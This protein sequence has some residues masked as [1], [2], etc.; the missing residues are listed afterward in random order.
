M[1]Y[2]M[3]I[4]DFIRDLRIKNGMTRSEL[5]EKIGIS[6]SHMNK[7][8]AG[9]RRPGM[10]TFE[11]ILEAFDADIFLKVQPETVHNKCLQKIQNVIEDVSEE[12]AVFLT[13]TLICMKHELEKL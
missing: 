1:R 3:K 6:D 4:A 2:S 11:K 13:N 10:D 12:Q 7:I 8:E 9:I 5:A